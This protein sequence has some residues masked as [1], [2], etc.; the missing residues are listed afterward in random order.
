MMWAGALIGLLGV[1]AGLLG[2]ELA[3]R[4]GPRIT[5]MGVFALSAVVSLLF[6]FSAALPYEAILVLGMAAGFIA[7]GNFSNLTSGVL[8]VA[9]PRHRGATVALYSCIGFAGGFAGTLAFGIALDHRRR[10]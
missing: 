4:V 7:R 10:R 3:L 5:A 6:G 9:D 2:N 1:P 8:M